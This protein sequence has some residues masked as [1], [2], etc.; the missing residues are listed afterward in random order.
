MTKQVHRNAIL[1]KPHLIMSVEAGGAEEM[2]AFRP[3]EGPEP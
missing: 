3:G 2:D 1:H